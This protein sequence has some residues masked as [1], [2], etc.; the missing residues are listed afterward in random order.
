MVTTFGWLR[1]EAAR[2]SGEAFL[3]VFAPRAQ[4]S[5]SMERATGR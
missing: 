4:I 2:L 3:A 1:L 5:R